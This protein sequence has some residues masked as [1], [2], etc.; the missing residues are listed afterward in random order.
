M[1][2]SDS[3]PAGAVR[4]LLT[5][6]GI[7]LSLPK[8]RDPCDWPAYYWTMAIRADRVREA[9]TDLLEE[10]GMAEAGLRAAA[11][12]LREAAALPLPYETGASH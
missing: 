11:Q 7:A 6:A 5:A 1:S 10:D 2:T 4:E 3:V 12:A 9:I 8:P